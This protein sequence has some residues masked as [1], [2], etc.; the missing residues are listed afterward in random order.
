MGRS[1]GGAG[2]LPRRR[3]A[4][5]MNGSVIAH[6][7]G[8]SIAPSVFPSSLLSASRTQ[9]SEILIPFQH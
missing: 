1:G 2:S 6:R 7:H 4:G 5:K 8:L 3:A 9:N